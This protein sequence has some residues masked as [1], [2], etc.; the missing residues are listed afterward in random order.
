MIAYYGTKILYMIF[1]ILPES[2][3]VDLFNYS[4]RCVIPILLIMVVPLVV[5]WI[6]FIRNLVFEKD[7]FL[8]LRQTFNKYINFRSFNIDDIF[9]T[10]KS[11]LP[12]VV[13]SVREVFEANGLPVK[14]LDDFVAN[15]NNINNFNNYSPNQGAQGTFNAPVQKLNEDKA[16]TQNKGD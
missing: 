15:V 1:E 11:V 12:L 4:F 13:F 2:N 8:A 5:I 7:L 16:Q 10:I 9:I 3:V 6:N 14:T